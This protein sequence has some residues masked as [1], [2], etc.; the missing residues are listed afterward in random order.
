MAVKKKTK[1]AMR[2]AKKAQVKKKVKSA[3]K[4]KRAKAKKEKPN[5]VVTAQ[6]PVTLIE[7]TLIDESQMELPIEPIDE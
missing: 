6:G 5:M 4:R 7:D 2:V 3:T 1:I